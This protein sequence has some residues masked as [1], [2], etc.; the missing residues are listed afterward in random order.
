MILQL[1][2]CLMIVA[3]I[4]GFAMLSWEV[5]IEYFLYKTISVVTITDYPEEVT[6][7]A[8]VFCAR[9][10]I[11]PRKE[12]KIGELFTGEKDFLSDRSDS[13]KAS[14][15]W[16][17][18]IIG[19]LDTVVK[20][21]LKAGKYCLFI[22]VK[23]K[24]KSEDIN[25]PESLPSFYR[26]IFSGEPFLSNN[27]FKAPR[28]KHPPGYFQ[29]ISGVSAISAYNPLLAHE[30]FSRIQSDR[31]YFVQLTY[32]LSISIKLPPPF[33]THC[34]DYQ[35]E[36]HFMSSNDCYDD[37]LK[38]ETL[39]YN[40]VPGHTVIDRQKYLNSNMDIAHL[41]IIE[42]ARKIEKLSTNSTLAKSLIKSYQLLH[43]KW[44]NIK[45]SCRHQCHRPDCVSEKITPQ[46]AVSYDGG[47]FNKTSPV[48]VVTMRS[49]DQ[50]ILQVSSVAKQQLLDYI[51][52]MCSGLSF[53]LG[54]C[55]LTIAGKIE[56]HFL[57]CVKTKK[58]KK[59]RSNTSC[60]RSHIP[61]A[62]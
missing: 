11:D 58:H 38:R 62:K 8:V 25:S 45:M 23:D 4:S 20:K 47:R 14:K 21:Y 41:N 30:V 29:V 28:Q 46:V 19:K 1:L 22:E 52:Y 13:W 49:S 34:L 55:P 17:S 37:C 50:A 54:F 48:F 33:D 60:R 12:Y 2:R 59:H 44:K 42:D 43:Y 36:G 26:V 10:N 24:F 40:V 5:T 35:S 31:V 6:A 3:I 51:V 16:S 39:R 15:V 53:W 27:I 56:R 18:I 7:P 57:K 32:T 9:F 61:N